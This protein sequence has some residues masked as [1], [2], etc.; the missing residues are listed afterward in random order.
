MYTVEAGSIPVPAIEFIDDKPNRP[1]FRSGTVKRFAG[2]IALTLVANLAACSADKKVTPAKVKPTITN[3]QTTTTIRPTIVAEPRTSG[4]NSEHF[5][6][7]GAA[8]Y[9]LQ[10]SGASVELDQTKPKVNRID[11]HSLMELAVESADGRQAVE[12][13]WIKSDTDPSTPPKLFVY[14]WVDGK[15]ACYDG[16]GFVPESNGHFAVGDP[17][18]VGTTGRY[19]IEYSKIGWTVDYN[20]YGLGHFPEKLWKNF[21]K[22]GLVQAFGEV[23]SSSLKPC[24]DMGNGKFGSSSGSAKIKYF[25]LNNSDTPVSFQPFEIYPSLYNVGFA[26]PTSVNIGGPGAC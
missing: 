14:H 23:A 26:T 11:E 1:G 13:G 10:A 24:T 5:I 7:A 15:P 4:Y 20:G 17:V 3:S 8:Q 25:K 12:V 9:G 22:V 18:E 2:V 6:Q 19:A 16:C 21:K